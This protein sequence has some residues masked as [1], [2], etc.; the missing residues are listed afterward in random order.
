MKC[1]FKL[2][3]QTSRFGI[4]FTIPCEVPENNVRVVVKKGIPTFEVPINHPLANSLGYAELI[5]AALPNNVV[6][7]VDRSY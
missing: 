6:Q 7:L 4:Q 5:A 2:P 1:E 3:R